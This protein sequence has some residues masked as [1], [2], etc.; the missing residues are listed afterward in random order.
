MKTRLTER[1]LNRIVRRVINEQESTDDD[2]SNLIQVMID[3]LNSMK[4]N[5]NFTADD[6][7]EVL[8]NNCNHFKNKTDIFAK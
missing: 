5:Q 4:D 3:K 8:I 1:D 2:K 7:C 6:V